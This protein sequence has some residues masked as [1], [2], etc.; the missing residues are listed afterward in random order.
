MSSAREG[1]C[2]AAIHYASLG[3]RVLPVHS[4]SSDGCSCGDPNCKSVGKHPRLS[5]WQR[6]A[7][8]DPE[9]ISSWWTAWPDGNIGIATGQRSGII[10][11][12]VDVGNG[13]DGPTSLAKLQSEFGPLPETICVNTGG[14]GRHLIS[15]GPDNR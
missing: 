6:R 15:N 1:L 9:T 3:W 14:G 4:A 2:D 13:K 8:T 7:S 12:D 5:K 10:A 11:I